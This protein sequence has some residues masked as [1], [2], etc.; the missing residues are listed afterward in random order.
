M[1]NVK[2]VPVLSITA[3]NLRSGE[4]PSFLKKLGTKAR[5][6]CAVSGGYL[7]AEISIVITDLGGNCLSLYDID[8]S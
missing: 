4:K 6:F 2:F 8:R 5:I 3:N 7:K 1:T